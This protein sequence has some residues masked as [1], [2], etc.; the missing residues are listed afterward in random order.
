M[1]EWPEVYPVAPFQDPAEFLAFL[2]I[3]QTLK[4][5]RTVEIGTY[6]GGTLYQWMRHAPAGAHIIAIDPVMFPE[7][8]AQWQS[9]NQH[10][11]LTTIQ[12]KSHLALLEVKE[13]MQEIDFLFIDGDHHYEQARWDFRHYSQLVRPGGVIA[14][15]D[16]KPVPEGGPWKTDMWRVWE[17]IQRAGYETVEISVHDDLFGI[18]VIFV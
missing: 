3:Y 6:Q 4:P 11:R 14:I 17:D 13:R 15:H 9:W 8:I 10:V 7:T 1:A 16:T 18:G 2:P 5:M 12:N